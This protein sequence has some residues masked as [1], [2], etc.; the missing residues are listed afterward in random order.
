MKKNKI[1]YI[2]G[3][4]AIAAF[5][6][7]NIILMCIYGVTTVSANAV[8]LIAFIGAILIISAL[9]VLFMLCIYY[10]IKTIIEK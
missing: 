10:M 1:K 9:A 2:V 5:I 3:L 7:A 8:I 6:L 4:V